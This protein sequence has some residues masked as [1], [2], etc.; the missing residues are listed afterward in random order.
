MKEWISLPSPLKLTI[1]RDIKTYNKFSMKWIFKIPK[2]ELNSQ[3]SEIQGENLLN[4]NDYENYCWWKDFSTIEQDFNMTWSPWNPICKRTITTSPHILYS[5]HP[6]L[7]HHAEGV[8][9]IHSSYKLL[10]MNERTSGCLII[11][12]ILHMTHTECCF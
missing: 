8:F 5:R 6:V 1:L 4:C 11:W 7:F 12:E 10:K 2:S 3:N 9:H